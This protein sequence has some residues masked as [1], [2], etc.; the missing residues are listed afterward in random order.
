MKPGGDRQGDGSTFTEKLTRLNLQ[1]LSCPGVQG[2]GRDL[3]MSSRSHSFC[4][5][6]KCLS[7]S[8]IKKGN[9]NILKETQVGD[10]I[11]FL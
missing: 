5:M 11:C 1:S 7:W 10:V 4:K 2:P 3:A 8:S 6:C 9:L